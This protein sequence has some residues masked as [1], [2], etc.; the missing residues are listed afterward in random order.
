MG[1]QGLR[2]AHDCLECFE[3][4]CSGGLVDS[5]VFWWVTQHISSRDEGMASEQG[6]AISTARC[7]PERRS[8]YW[9][10]G[11]GA[12]RRGCGGMCRG[13]CCWTG[14]LMMQLCARA[15]GEAWQ[16]EHNL[17]PLLPSICL[18]LCVWATT[19]QNHCVC[20]PAATVP[21]QVE[22]KVHRPLPIGTTR[23]GVPQ[24]HTHTPTHIQVR[25]K[26]TVGA[27]CTISTAA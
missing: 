4:G 7:S 23:S 9:Q 22:Y 2:A 14:G 12:C 17:H 19:Q 25:P 5:G 3:G 26:V 13:A 6:T 11:L 24:P 10:E 8:T 18:P 21:L 16:F 1:G 15:W 20:H 27:Q